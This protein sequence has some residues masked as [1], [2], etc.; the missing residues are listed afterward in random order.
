MVRGLIPSKIQ[1]YMWDNCHVTKDDIQIHKDCDPFISETKTEQVL[2]NLINNSLLLEELRYYMS[3]I[4]VGLTTINEQR[5]I[6]RNM[7]EE[8][9][10]VQN[11]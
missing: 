9:S 3:G 8:I 10:N 1:S 5:K 6:C 11:I 4:K 7:L 2:N